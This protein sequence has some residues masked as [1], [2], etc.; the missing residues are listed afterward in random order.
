MTPL[1]SSIQSSSI[2]SS[3]IQSS[4][5]QSS[6][7]HTHLRPEP[8]P[9]SHLA[10]LVEGARVELVERLQ[11]AVCKLE[12]P[13]I[14]QQGDS[15][16]SGS[17]ALDRLLPERGFAAGSLIEW[18]TSSPGSGAASL[19]MIA[20]REAM[21]EGGAVVVMDRKRQF[22]PPAAAALGLDLESLVVVRAAGE[23]DELW[24]LDQALR[25]PGV[26]AVWAELDDLDWR[27]FRRL[28][29]AAEDG[30]AIGLFQRPLRVRGQPTW[31]ASQLLVQPCPGHGPRRFRIEVL[32]CRGGRGGGVVE[33]EMDD[34][35]GALREVVM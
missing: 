11:D 8:V 7:T 31:S 14:A 12:R 20:A 28:Q 16:S 1:P 21:W 4:S 23:A 13:R 29:L 30:G 19:G 18:L 2:Q 9:R 17:A 34:V 3:S 26:A 6:S 15:I 33:L 22:Y 32:R 35:T 10:P 24:A 25:C 5:I 27:W